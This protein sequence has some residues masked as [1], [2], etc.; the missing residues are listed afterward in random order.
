MRLP[1]TLHVD[2]TLLKKKEENKSIHAAT[3][4]R[5]PPRFEVHRFKLLGYADDNA[6]VSWLSH[7]FL[8]R[9][10]KFNR[11]NRVSE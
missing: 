3:G 4:I 1:A 7:F 2:L 8:A 5:D 10:I 11:T 9:K 6:S